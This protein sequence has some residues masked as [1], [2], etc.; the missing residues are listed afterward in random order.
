MDTTKMPN[1]PIVTPPM[2][3]KKKQVPKKKANYVTIY[4]RA[5]CGTTCD[6]LDYGC[7]FCSRSCMIEYYTY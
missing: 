4:C 1:S 5:G 7:G 6:A 3:P 2:S